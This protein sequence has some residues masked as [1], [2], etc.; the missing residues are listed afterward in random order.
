MLSR[1]RRTA[2]DLQTKGHN[3]EKS[4]KILTIVLPTTAVTILCAGVANYRAVETELKAETEGHQSEMCELSAKEI[5][6]SL[7]S[8]RDELTW[9]ARHPDVQSMNWDSMSGYLS[10]VAGSAAERLTN[11]IVIE[12]NGDY[13][14]A[15]RGKVEN[16]NL[17]DRKY[18]RD[19]MGDGSRF[20]MTSPDYSRLTNQKKYTLA[21]PIH[22][23]GESAKGCLAS[24]ISLDILSGMVSEGNKGNDRLLWVVDERTYVIGCDDKEMLLEYRLSDAAKDCEGMDALS[25]GIKRRERTSGYVTM[26]DGRRYFATCQ[27]IGGTPGWAL[28]SAVAESNMT[29]LTT[30]LIIRTLIAP[31]VAMTVIAVTVWRVMKR[32]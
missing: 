30:S 28:V 20:S 19:I 29:R 9:V 22:A 24:N 12:P 14:F 7:K 5:S 17:S 13:Y 21:V 16:R 25:E 10:E 27:P 32:G 4:A 8:I 6:A 26:E 1:W 23:E 2:R 3:M 11:L 15:G 31:A 18:F